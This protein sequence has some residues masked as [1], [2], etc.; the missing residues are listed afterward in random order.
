MRGPLSH[1]RAAAL[2]ASGIWAR[3][4]GEGEA[5][6]LIRDRLRSPEAWRAFVATGHDA[7]D[8]ATSRGGSPV[9]AAWP[10]ERLARLRLRV[11]AILFDPSLERPGFEPRGED[12]YHTAEDDEED[13]EAAV[14]DGALDELLRSDPRERRL[15]FDLVRT[16]TAGAPREDPD[17]GPTAEDIPGPYRDRPSFAAVGVGEESPES[18]RKRGAGDSGGGSGTGSPGGTE[19]AD[20]GGGGSA[21]AETSPGSRGD[22]S[23]KKRARIEDVEGPAEGKLSEGKLSRAQVDVGEPPAIAPPS[24]RADDDGWT[25]PIDDEWR[26]RTLATRLRAVARARGR[27]ADLTVPTVPPADP[28]RPFVEGSFPPSFR[29]PPRRT[30]E[31]MRDFL[32]ASR[33]PGFAPERWDVRCAVPAL[34]GGWDAH[35]RSRVGGGGFGGGGF[36]GG[37]VGGSFDGAGGD[38]RAGTREIGG[39]GEV[40]G[41]RFFARVLTGDDASRMWRRAVAE[42]VSANVR[43]GGSDD[44]AVG[45]SVVAG[46]DEATATALAEIA[47]GYVT[48]LGASIRVAMDA[49]AAAER[50]EAARREAAA[51]GGNRASFFATKGEFVGAATVARCVAATGKTTLEGLRA[52]AATGALE[53]RTARTRRGGVGVAKVGVANVGVAAGVT[54]GVTH[55]ATQLDG[56]AV[57]G[58][59]VGVGWD[60]RLG[61]IVD[62]TPTWVRASEG[63]RGPG[64]VPMDAWVDKN[65]NPGDS[66][67]PPGFRLSQ[68]QL[69]ALRQQFRAKGLEPSDADVQRYQHV[70]H[71]QMTHRARDPP[72]P[73]GVQSRG[74][75]PPGSHKLKLGAGGVSAPAATAQGSRRPTSGE[76]VGDPRVTS[77]AEWK[78]DYREPQRQDMG[79]IHLQQ[80]MHL[81]Q[82][83]R[84]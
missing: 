18:D 66:T 81:Q 49:R 20:S 79:R 29:S 78:H 48:K 4:L 27:A 50:R 28:S 19:G 25:G 36:G 38:E 82:E 75:L 64:A 44:D 46:F 56:A 7:V 65:A 54:H 33:E 9:D 61:A 77:P 26:N 37:A 51:G 23:A 22:D 6:G 32:A 2:E 17:E 34:P 55:G 14:A 60:A 8:D 72:P 10:V 13:W 73:G 63:G 80:Q 59:D 47:A 30:P 21:E 67:S 41:D 35:A 40:G 12:V 11:R 52:F 43:A 76:M 39:D 57:A 58:L 71:Q 68:Q 74:T 45:E 1:E 62:A 69:A 70:L 5:L 3:W 42:I 53:P 83:Q 16:E 84:K 24:L 31:G 15:G